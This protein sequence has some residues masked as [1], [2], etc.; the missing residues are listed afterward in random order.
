MNAIEPAH[1]GDAALWRHCIRSGRAAASIVATAT[2]GVLR[3]HP[4]RGQPMGLSGIS[5]SEPLLIFVVLLLV[6]GSKKLL[7]I[8]SDLGGAAR[9]ATP[10]AP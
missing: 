2:A 9:S 8:A 7:G 5:F 1:A 6:L 10:A 4:I 3:H